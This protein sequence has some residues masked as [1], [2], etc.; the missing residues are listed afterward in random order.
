MRKITRR[1][2]IQFAEYMVG[3]TTYFWSGYIVF[4]ICYSGLGWEWWPA[5]ML[6]DVVG[7]TLNYLIQ[8]YWAFSSPSLAKKEAATLQKYTL[9]TIFNLGLDY[10]IVGGLNAIGVTPYI[11]FFISAGFFMVWNY[12]WYRFWVFNKKVS[13]IDI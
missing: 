4:A 3:G 10:A 6:A 7:W 9:V 12:A 8:R 5:K 13:K 1:E 2:L 11:G